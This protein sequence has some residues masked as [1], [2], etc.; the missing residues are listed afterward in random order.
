MMNTVNISPSSQHALKTMNRH[1]SYSYKTGWTGP[2]AHGGTPSVDGV[3]MDRAR[4]TSS[5]AA[6]PP[7]RSGRQQ[8]VK[9]TAGRGRPGARGTLEREGRGQ[10][11]TCPRA[12]NLDLVREEDGKM[13]RSNLMSWK[14]RS[15]KYTVYSGFKVDGTIPKSLWTIRKRH[16]AG[17][18]AICSET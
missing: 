12:N 11:K 14:R 4:W 3:E 15:A 17:P 13:E 9:P 1:A 7:S 10:L 6:T 2:V 18:Y 5:K 16:L 8:G